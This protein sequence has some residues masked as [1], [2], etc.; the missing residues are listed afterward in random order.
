[1]LA[2]AGR[3]DQ[4][5]TI[6][7]LI[8]LVATAQFLAQPADRHVVLIAGVLGLLTYL[9][10]NG[11]SNYFHLDPPEDE[12]DD[13]ESSGASGSRVRSAAALAT[14]KAA[15]MLFLYLEVLDASFSS[16]V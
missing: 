7:A 14:G 16:T 9:V 6:F 13:G 5:S 10:V 4:A 12:L 8:V 1:M 11:L 3:L 2:R 15:F